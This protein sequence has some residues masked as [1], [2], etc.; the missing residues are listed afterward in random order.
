METITQD[1]RWM[2]LALRQAEL[3]GEAGEVPVGAVLVQDNRLLAE[4]GNM[5]ISTSDPTAHAEIRVLRRAA[6]R[7]G[8][9][10]LPDTT[11]Y[12]TLEPCPMCA[13]AILHARVS[14][15]VF[16]AADPKTGALTSL[17]RIGR[18]GKFNHTLE[19]CGGVLEESCAAL[20][21]DFFAAR[22]KKGS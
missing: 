20:L 15:V 10:R 9:Y 19:V 13:G 12:V 17:Y 2:E 1:R 22:R 8:N 3:S 4:A 5:P 16:G 21:K 7:L 18:D 11:L 14:R 6:A